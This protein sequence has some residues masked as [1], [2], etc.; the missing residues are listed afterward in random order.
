MHDERSCRVIRD[1]RCSGCSWHGRRLHTE[2]AP[3]RRRH[4]DATR[5]WLCHWRRHRKLGPSA[6]SALALRLLSAAV[7]HLPPFLPPLRQRREWGGR[8]EG[9]GSARASTF[10]SSPRSISS[11]LPCR[12]PPLLAREPPPRASVTA[13][14]TPLLSSLFSSSSPRF[15]SSASPRLAS[16]RLAAPLDSFSV[17]RVVLSTDAAGI[18]DIPALR[19][20]SSMDAGRVPRVPVGRCR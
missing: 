18:A 15:A 8:G 11:P 20:R 10:S 7:L 3:R 14:P 13:L 12:H 4:A 1:D 2:G 5:N 17:G 19:S 9:R 16:P 6:D